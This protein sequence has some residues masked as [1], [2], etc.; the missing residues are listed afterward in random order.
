MVTLSN[1]SLLLILA[2]MFFSL[3]TRNGKTHSCSTDP[4][5]AC[6]VDILT[7]PMVSTIA[8]LTPWWGS[9]PTTNKN[10]YNMTNTYAM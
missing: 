4:R 6:G 3:V 9:N 8:L 7:L 5:A 1:V 10:K 2:A